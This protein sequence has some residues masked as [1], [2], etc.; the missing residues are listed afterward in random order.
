MTSNAKK[1]NAALA[2]AA[3]AKKKYLV[4]GVNAW[5]EFGNT[6]WQEVDII[7]ANQADESL[8]VE[9]YL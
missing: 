3:T 2:A 1:E 8:T 5:V 6:G 7:A 4:K 9:V